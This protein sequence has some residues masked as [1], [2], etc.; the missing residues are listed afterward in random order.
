MKRFDAII[1]GAGQAG[2]SLAGRL[3]SA[4]MSVA[5]VER[6]YFGGTCI[7]T[8]C[9]PTKTL[10]ASARAAHV[11]RRAADFGVILEKNVGIDMRRVKARAD[12]ITLESRRGI[13]SWL[14]GMRGCTVVRGHARFE[15]RDILRVGDEQL[16]SNR[17]FINVG[18][19]AL[20]PKLPRVGE[21]SY[22]T[23]SSIL[24]LDTVPDHLVIVG[25]SYIG[26][27]FG[28]MIRRFGAKVTV[29]EK[30]SHLISHEDEDISE[31]IEEIFAREEIAVRTNATCIGFEPAGQGVCVRVDCKDGDPIVAGSHVLLAVGR[32]P[33]T[34]DLG[35]E[36]AGVKTDARGYI[37]V[38]DA[39]RTNVSTIWAL[40]E[41]NGHGAFTHTAYDDYEIV[42][43][44]ML[45]HDERRVSDRISA[46]A[47]YIDPPLGRVG[48]SERS[49]RAA[50]RS[51]LV[52]KRPMTRVS[53]ANERDE[54]QGFMKILVDP[55]TKRILGAAILG[56]EGDEV[57]QMINDHMYT[58][59]PYTTLRRAVGIHPTVAE[60]VPT[61]LGDLEPAPS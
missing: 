37:V 36:H 24:E 2:P 48:E 9:M 49:L 20:V 22:L 11:A 55:D 32:Q 56:I 58:R 53:R 1:I 35:L 57:I 44:N 7:N 5:I 47:L 52:A 42:A 43:A 29:L 10:I 46:Y 3:T 16:A 25:G 39:L 33:N 34:D 59:A 14:E 8:G 30:T 45:D 51:Y 40:G 15:A 6:K 31:S 26:L 54:T 13:E 27:E 23:N 50:G 61:L 17:M 12:K 28:Q 18:G 60:L 41:C 38:D 21:V 4:G 19:R